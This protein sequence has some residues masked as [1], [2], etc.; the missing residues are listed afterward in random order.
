M[1]S[2]ALKNCIPTSNRF[3][4][5]VGQPMDSN[6]PLDQRLSAR[7]NITPPTRALPLPLPQ[8]PSPSSSSSPSCGLKSSD[9]NLQIH[10]LTIATRSLIKLSG[11][12]AGKS[13]VFLLDCG[14]TGNFV[15]AEFVRKHNLSTKPL[16]HQ[17]VITLAD[18]SQQKAGS[19]V[20]AAVI[21]I[22]SY[23]DI[24]DFVSLPLA[25]YDIILGM[26][27]LDHFNPSV[28]WKKHVVSL[29]DA[30]KRRHVLRASDKPLS[31]PVVNTVKSSSSDSSKESTKLN[32]GT[33]VSPEKK[34]QNTKA[35]MLLNVI[36]SKQVKRAHQTQQ[37]DSEFGCLV[38]V[39]MPPSG[40]VTFTMNGKNELPKSSS[41][42]SS[43]TTVGEA[44]LYAINKLSV[45]EDPWKCQ[46]DHIAKE[47]VKEYR[48]AFPE[49]LPPGLPPSR[50]IDHKIELVAGA[51]P[52]SRPTFR[53]SATELAE[54]KKQL[55]ELIKSGFIRP[56]KSPFGAPILFVKK[57]D[58]TMRMCVDYRALNEITIKNKYP[59]PR[60][61]EL[62]DRLQGAQYFSKIDL[63]SGYHQIRI[64]DQDIPKTAFRTR[65]GHF[66][67]LVL[68]FGLTNAPATFMHLMHET[69]R[70][71][72]DDF[73]IVFL[74]DI[75]IYS[76]TLDD[77]ERHVRKVLDILR[78]QK[79]YAKESK[80]E[81]FKEEVEF[82]GHIVGRSGIRMMEDKVKAVREWPTP[83]KATDVRSFLGT[84]GYYRRFIKDFSAIAASLTDLTK[85]YVKFNWNKEQQ[86]AFDSLKSCIVKGPVLILPDPNLPFVVHTDASGFAIGAV[87]QQDQGKGL[88][89]IAFLSKKMLDAETRYPV[90]EQE[91]L[92]IMH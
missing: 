48:D 78:E 87:L 8:S 41:P 85:D 89:P 19:I 81:L 11:F 29:V 46:L 72:L 86:D 22:G 70:S 6:D 53:M 35:G 91:L 4:A 18:G 60:V 82:L 52:P 80:C 30:K 16:P 67:F 45:S 25:G 12:V 79:L 61:D 90:H 75:L 17:D 33:S 62:F 15:S 10:Q 73:V 63:R 44:F 71:Y 57:K 26:P 43:T 31:S 14:A 13:A 21:S 83:T 69:F 2:P 64:D 74:D 37:L 38:Y 27:W 7:E 59:L 50:E 42:S 36:T 55:E 84:A 68:P 23:T 58:G 77:H 56:S 20:N 65:Y 92:A 39:G 49:E 66:E 32:D 51:V 40:E 34:K 3:N 88:Q 5:L 47:F 54:L 76:K 1:V 24:L 9:S 28:N